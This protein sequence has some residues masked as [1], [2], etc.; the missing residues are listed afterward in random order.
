M[1]NRKELIGKLNLLLAEHEKY[2][3]LNN[4][5]EM[6]RA[7]GAIIA[8]SWS[9]GLIETIFADEESDHHILMDLEAK[10]NMNMRSINP[11]RLKARLFVRMDEGEARGLVSPKTGRSPKDGPEKG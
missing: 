11:L 6:S 1:R 5:E 2:K 10:G 9:L 8:L 7:E 3:A 4:A